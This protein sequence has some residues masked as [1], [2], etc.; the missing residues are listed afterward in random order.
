MR[1][2]WRFVALALTVGSP[3]GVVAQKVA[4]PTGVSVA[5]SNTTFTVS[6][7][8]MANV[9]QYQVNQREGTTVKTLGSVPASPF[10]M[11]PCPT[12]GTAYDYQVVSIGKGPKNMAASPWVPYTVPAE[13]PVASGAPRTGGI[14]LDPTVPRTPPT[15]IPAGPTSLTAGSTIPGQINLGWREVANATAYR[16]TRSSDAPQPEQ[17]IA[18]YASTDQLAEGG[19]WYHKDA[20]VDDRWTFT[21]KVYALFGTTVSTPSP[22]ASA[23]SIAVIQ[24][25]GLKYGVT[26]APGAAPGLVT[27]TLSWTGVPNVDRYIITGIGFTGGAF[28]YTKST[29]YVLNNVPASHTYPVCVGA[30]YPYD[31]QDQHTA[32]CIDVKLQ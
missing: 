10:T 2:T 28:A 9:G 6:W 14:P 20:P 16:V 22:Q 4:A 30:I 27:V 23:K 15:V 31:V 29:S 21:Y 24:P 7:N 19:Q 5:C 1:M 32:P 3:A 26:I 25:T 8:N 11:S 13:V 17:Q 18:Q 12:G